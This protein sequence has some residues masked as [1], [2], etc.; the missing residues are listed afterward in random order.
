MDL[1]RELKKLWNMEVKIIPIVIG[2]F[3]TFSK[4]LLKELE[5]LGIRGRVWPSKLLHNWERPEYWE[6]SWRFEATCCL[7]NFSE[8]P[9]AKADVKN[10]NND[11]NNNKEDHPNYY[12]V[13]IGEKTEKSPGDLRKLAVTQTSVR[14]NRPT[15]EW[16]TLKVL[17]N[18]IIILLHWE[19]F[20]PALADGFLQEFERQQVASSF[21]DSSQ[22]SG[23]S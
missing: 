8:R 11:N 4:G 16:K 9:S 15:F 21:Q 20:T 7:S 2:A 22:Y 18:N 23:R 5:D 1:A 14:N 12:I 3:G 13:E 19:L 17:N 10:S 6:E